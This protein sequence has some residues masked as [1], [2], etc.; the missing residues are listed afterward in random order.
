[1]TTLSAPPVTPG[2]VSIVIP[3]FNPGRYLAVAVESAFAQTYGAVE[4][5]VVD[6]GSTEDV[7]A[8]LTTWPRVRYFRQ[9]NRGV[10]AAR[11]L[12]ASH[13]R[14]EFLVFLDADDRLL[15]DA[16]EGGVEEL[17]G[18]PAAVFAAGLCR[19]IGPSGEPLP[20]KQRGDVSGDPY[21]D[22]LQGNFIWMP[23][24]VVYRRLAFAVLGGFDGSADACA[25]YDLYLRAMRTHP[26]VCHRRLV[27]EYRFH[28]ANMSGDKAL[29]LASALR[30]LDRQWRYVRRHPHHREAY[31]KGRR[32]WRE[33]Y[34]SGLVE[35]IRA[36]IR[37]PT[38]R[39]RAMRRAAVLLRHHPAE[40]L[41]QLGRKIRCLMLDLAGTRS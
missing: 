4:V 5:V 41:R 24:Q 20:F 2:L 31:A 19:P 26:V 25:D 37:T 18:S 30:V 15:P 13:G 23:A 8:L 28:H 17:R 11:N 10:S 40:A 34:G 35:D 33:Y 6:D 14:G 29:M 36:D 16:V 12:G 9:P 39:R 38:S 22:M 3:C 1:M 32:F 27:A 21:V 7:R